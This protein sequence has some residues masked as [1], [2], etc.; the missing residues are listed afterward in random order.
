MRCDGSIIKIAILSY[1]FADDYKSV[2]SR[3]QSPTSEESKGVSGSFNFHQLHYKHN[4]KTAKTC[5]F[6]NRWTYYLPD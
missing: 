2:L 6:N 4:L 5:Q 1:Q 3:T